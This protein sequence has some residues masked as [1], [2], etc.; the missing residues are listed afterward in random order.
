MLANQA[1]ATKPKPKVFQKGSLY[2][3]FPYEIYRYLSAARNQPVY[4]AREKQ[5][6]DK[7]ERRLE[8]VKPQ[9][10]RGCAIVARGNIFDFIIDNK[11]R[12]G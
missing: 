10:Q 5:Y 2:P 1:K 8:E 3:E 4:W 12:Y 9:C 7:A 11:G 6:G